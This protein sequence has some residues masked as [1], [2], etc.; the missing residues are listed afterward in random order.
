M[1]N[2]LDP[3][4]KGFIL[5]AQNGPIELS[6]AQ[7]ALHT[8]LCDLLCFFVTQHSFRSKF[9]IL[10][11]SVTTKVAALL[12]AKPKHLRLAA[13]RYFRASVGRNDDF[14]NR[15]LVKNDIFSPLLQLTKVEVAANNLLS[16]A[17]L[18]FFEYIRITNIKILLNHLNERF[19]DELK[20]LATSF[21]VFRGLISKWEQN[22]EPAP[23]VSPAV[24]EIHGE[25]ALST[26]PD[27][28]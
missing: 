3:L 4:T 28:S 25:S 17:C 7:V 19:G 9:F 20:N 26:S 21:D 18:E 16:S 5:P 27:P 12:R 6:T 14:Y 8:H 1:A 24:Q 15:Y 22:N 11:S 2:L 23:R 10:S 13:L